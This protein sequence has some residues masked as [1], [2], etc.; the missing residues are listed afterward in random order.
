[1]TIRREEERKRNN[2]NKTQKRIK[3]ERKKGEEHTYMHTEES[4][5]PINKYK[6]NEGSKFFF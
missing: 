4:N 6:K 1:L 5:Q 2:D 3:K